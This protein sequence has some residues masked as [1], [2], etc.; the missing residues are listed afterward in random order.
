MRK[1]DLSTYHQE[2]MTHGEARAAFEADWKEK[3]DNC[4]WVPVVKILSLR[5]GRENWTIT[6]RIKKEGK[7]TQ[8]ISPTLALELLSENLVG[9]HIPDAHFV[10]NPT[11]IEEMVQ[12]V[13]G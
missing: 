13:I 2:G 12:V 6:Y 1:I 9:C 8:A 3:I 10:V 7:V 4:A 5:Q 11:R